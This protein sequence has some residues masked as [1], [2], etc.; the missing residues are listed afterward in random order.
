MAK[1]LKGTNSRFRTIFAQIGY[2]FFIL[3]PLKEMFSG[4]FLIRKFR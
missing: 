2:S 3:D 1:I 4:K